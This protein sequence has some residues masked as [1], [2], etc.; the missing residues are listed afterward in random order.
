MLF[1]NVF[2]NDLKKKKEKKKDV[3][4]LNNCEYYFILQWRKFLVAEG[5]IEDNF[6]R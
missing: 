4:L 5:W 2:R 6:R 3:A 1:F